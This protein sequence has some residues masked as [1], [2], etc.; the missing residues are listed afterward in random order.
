ME[1]V[2]KENPYGFL[3]VFWRDLRSGLVF[4]AVMLAFFA[5]TTNSMVNL[6][7][8]HPTVF[9]S[10]LIVWD[11]IMVIALLWLWFAAAHAPLIQVL[12]EIV[13]LHKKKLLI[14]R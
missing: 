6:A 12:Y 10:T 4:F 7:V 8:E 3:K 14:Y 5:I 13:D 2:H 1:Y 9:F 11:M